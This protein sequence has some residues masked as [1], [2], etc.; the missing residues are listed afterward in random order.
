[1]WYSDFD[2]LLIFYSPSSEKL[3]VKKSSYK[4]LSKFLQVMQSREFLVVKEF[5]KG[6]ENIVEIDFT[7]PE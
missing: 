3:D 1:M 7:H 4:K 6:V 2:V 5:P